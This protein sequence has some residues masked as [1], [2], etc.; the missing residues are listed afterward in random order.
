MHGIGFVVQSSHSKLTETEQYIFDEVLAMFGK[1]I[2]NFFLV[3]TSADI[4][5]APQ[6]MGAVKAANSPFQQRFQDC[7]KFNNSALFSSANSDNS[8]INGGS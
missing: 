6:V 7:F 4:V 8:C 5:N 2:G 3:A 1:D